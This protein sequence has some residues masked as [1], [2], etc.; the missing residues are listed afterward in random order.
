MSDIIDGLVA[1]AEGRAPEVVASWVE[2]AVEAGA[3][4]IAKLPDY[5]QPLARAA[6]D[7]LE[8]NK[9]ALGTMSQTA[10][11]S[12]VSKIALGQGDEAQ[13][14]YLSTVATFG[15]RMAALDAASVATRAEKDGRVETWKTI[16]SVS[17]DILLGL[18]K[19]ALPFL[20]AVL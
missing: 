14:M 12:V 6:L 18:G 20:I 16:K 13:R 8:A 7:K 17:E 10:F 5:M 3:S 9:G 1:S 2:K 4:Q 11:V 19:A 15:E